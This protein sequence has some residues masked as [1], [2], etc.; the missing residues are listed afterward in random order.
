MSWKFII[1]KRILSIV[2]SIHLNIKMNLLG[3][4]YFVNIDG[5]A[6]MLRSKNPFAFIIWLI[7]FVSSVA[8]TLFLIVSAVSGFLRY[9]VSST[10]R[11]L[12]EERSLF[13][14]VTLCNINPFTTKYAINL[15]LQANVTMPN[16]GE[17][18]DYWAMY[19]QVEDYMRETRG[20][21]LTLEEKLK[22]SSM[23]AYMETQSY[24]LDE[25]A[26]GV[27]GYV[28]E[29]QTLGSFIQI[30]VPR[31]F[32]CLVFNRNGSMSVDLANI[33]LMGVFITAGEDENITS[34]F[35]ANTKGFYMFLHN[36]SD[37]VY[38]IAR[39]AS[40]L[41]PGLMTKV[42]VDRY[43]YHQHV[44]PYSE[45]GVLEDNSLAI[46][47]ADRSIFDEVIATNSSYTR[48]TCLAFCTQI[49]ISRRCGCQS[50]RFAYN[51]ANVPYCSMKDELG[52]AE[53]V[54]N[55]PS[56][57][58]YE[59]MDKCPLECSLMQFNVK[60]Y[61][62]CVR[63]KYDAFFPYL[64]AT[65]VQANVVEVT[66]QYNDL[67]YVE[68][69][70]EPKNGK[71]LFA[72]VGGHLHL[73]LGMSLMSFVQIFELFCLSVWN[74]LS[75]RVF[76]R[77][78]THNSD[79]F[80]KPTKRLVYK[81][82]TNEFHMNNLS[83]IKMDCIPDAVRASH[84]CLSLFWLVLF[85]SSACACV[86][87]IYDTVLMFNKHR[88]TTTVAHSDDLAIAIRF[89][90]AL[91]LQTDLTKIL[92]E[93]Y[94]FDAFYYNLNGFWDIREKISNG[95]IN[96]SSL[97]NK[98]DEQLARLLT[99]DASEMVVDCSISGKACKFEFYYDPNYIA[100]Y[101]VM[102]ETELGKHK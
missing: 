2:Y 33:E 3:K 41:S 64:P 71:E 12:T 88:V 22:L 102:P 93:S 4:L 31:Y 89:C 101:R 27:G 7:M 17:T 91:P 86:Y 52:C 18:V 40:I 36:S 49:L 92:Y 66:I 51:V 69:R 38:E 87:L 48:Q 74:L 34:M 62:K 50:N 55:S 58:N 95:I 85:L 35:A 61:Q 10:V 65:I 97:L 30:F 9:D 53:E 75:S 82:K 54:W 59:C 73:L 44:N 28:P 70:E 14:T 25:Y 43:F 77:A 76:S 78:T 47:L 68:T 6:R 20:Y 67:A 19:L 39:P 5:L 96:E 79:Q 83:R 63:N 1:H 99:L 46:N 11:Y 32:N 42:S 29:G 13:P 94:P 80:E 21:A 16:E 72:S 23:T 100:C 8:V 26:G 45:C 81:N 56:D 57:I 60:Q 24:T 15:L 84:K 98:T 37:Y 90:S